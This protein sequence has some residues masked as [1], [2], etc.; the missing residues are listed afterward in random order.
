MENGVGWSTYTDVLTRIS[1]D[2]LRE[3]LNFLTMQPPPGTRRYLAFCFTENALRRKKR[4]KARAPAPA[5]ATIPNPENQVL[6]AFSTGQWDL[7]SGTLQQ[8]WG[9]STTTRDLLLDLLARMV[10]RVQEQYRALLPTPS[11]TPPLRTVWLCIRKTVPD[12]PAPHNTRARR[13]YPW[14]TVVTKLGF[15]PAPEYVRAR[16]NLPEVGPDGVWRG[17]PLTVELFD[18]GQMISEAARDEF[19][20]MCIDLGDL[21]PFIT[22]VGS[23]RHV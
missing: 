17:P 21:P 18:K 5:E 6:M 22:A 20:E 16:E 13:S 4:G 15:V 11:L 1:G 7:P 3:V 9:Q 2:S 23:W 14:E 19:V 8:T 12:G 10:A